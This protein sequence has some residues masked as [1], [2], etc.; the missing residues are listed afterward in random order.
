MKK[1]KLVQLLN[2]HYINLSNVKYV[3]IVKVANDTGQF[4]V[5][6]NSTSGECINNIFKNQDAALNWLRKHFDIIE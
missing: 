5:K 3:K 6:L 1:P 2:G 4:S